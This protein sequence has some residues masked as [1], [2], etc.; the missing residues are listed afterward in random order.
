MGIL[1][2][3][4]EEVIDGNEAHTVELVNKSIEMGINPM[5]VIRQ[6][7]IPA[8][9][10]VGML[11]QE[12]KYF[13]PEMIFSSVAMEAGMKVAKS[14]INIG[15]IDKKGT[16]IIGTVEGDT[17]D[18]GKNIV[19]LMLRSA[20]FE[21]TDLGSDVSPKMFADAI[22][23]KD[24][25]ILAMSSLLTTTMFNMKATIDLLKESGL[26]DT[27]KIIVGGAVVNRDFAKKIGADEYAEDAVKA[28]E[29][30]TL[31]CK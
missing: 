22:V 13:L 7:L 20:G 10:H 18:I 15:D 23:A 26:R 9:E 3:L 14:H 6:A 5:D 12:G 1:E 2:D 19:T 24:A 29:A 31:L 8:M 21:V 17:H 27:V 25:N 11:F 16:V 4:F 30:A 28:V